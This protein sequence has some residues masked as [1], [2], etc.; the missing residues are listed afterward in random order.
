[1]SKCRQNQI[2][3]V[4]RRGKDSNPSSSVLATGLQL[5]LLVSLVRL[6]FW[7]IGAQSPLLPV[8]GCR[9]YCIPE[10]RDDGAFGLGKLAQSRIDPIGQARCK[11]NGKLSILDAMPRFT[12]EEFAIE[13]EEFALG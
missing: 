1:M 12:F 3:I 5:D 2:R 4:Q 11:S 13:V 6:S 7:H 9:G 8:H 10:P